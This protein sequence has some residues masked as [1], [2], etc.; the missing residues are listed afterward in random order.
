MH[1][2][3]NKNDTSIKWVENPKYAE[4]E[5][6]IDHRQDVVS[7]LAERMGVDVSG[8]DDLGKL[9]DA[10]FSTR[11]LVTAEQMAEKDQLRLNNAE[12]VQMIRRGS[13]LIN[14]STDPAIGDDP[15]AT[16]A[17]M[18][19]IR[20]ESPLATAEDG[21]AV[22]PVA[23][24]V[25][26]VDE[27][28]KGRSEGDGDRA[29]VYRDKLME[30][31]GALLADG[32]MDP[33]HPPY[34]LNAKGEKESFAAGFPPSL[35]LGRKTQAELNAEA[36]KQKEAKVRQ[37][38]KDAAQLATRS[39]D[40]VEEAEQRI[41]ER[42]QK[43]VALDQ[44]RRDEVKNTDSD[45]L[46]DQGKERDPKQKARPTPAQ[47]SLDLSDPDTK[48]PP[49]WPSLPTKKHDAPTARYWDEPHAPATD[50]SVPSNPEAG[51]RSMPGRAQ[52]QGELGGVSTANDVRDAKNGAPSP[53]SIR[54][55]GP[56]ITRPGQRVDEKR[57]G[58]YP[59][60]PETASTRS[61]A[62]RT[63]LD[64]EPEQTEGVPIDR[65]DIR[66][67]T[68][69][70]NAALDKIQTLTAANAMGRAKDIA[71][72][73]L[74]M[75]H[76]F[77]GKFEG[78][79]VK[80][81]IVA[82]PRGAFKNIQ[83]MVDG[84]TRPT[85][86]NESKVA[87][88]PG[89]EQ[90]VGGKFYAAPLA[91]I[92]TPKNAEGIVALAKDKQRAQA[93]VDGWRSSVASALL[94]ATD[95]E[96]AK[97][98]KIALAKLLTG[99]NKLTTW[100]MEKELGAL[101]KTPAVVAKAEPAPASSDF[102][103]MRVPDLM[104]VDAAKLTGRELKAWTDAVGEA[105][106][107]NALWDHYNES[108]YLS[109][110]QRL[111]KA[112]PTEG[113]KLS[114]AGT[115]ERLAA[116]EV[117]NGPVPQQESIRKALAYVRKVLGPNIK[118]EFLKDF[119]ADG[120]WV[121]AEQ[122]IKLA[123]NRGSGLETTAHHEA[124][125]G[126]FSRLLKHNPDAAKRLAG[127]MS[128]KNDDAVKQLNKQIVDARSLLERIEQS[129]K[130]RAETGPD[131]EAAVGAKH[132]KMNELAAEIVAATRKIKRLEEQDSDSIYNRLKGLLR[133]S[134][135][136]LAAM[137]RDPE[138]RVAYAYQFWVAG[139]LEVDK[140][141]TTIFAKFRKMLRKVLGMVRESETALDI[142]TAFH[143]G[144][145]AD[146]DAGAKA[147]KKIM[148]REK[149]NEDVKMKFDKVISTLH[150]ELSPAHEVLS[151]EDLSAIVRGIGDRMFTNPG[152]A[153]AMKNPGYINLRTTWANKFTNWQD[154]AVG[155]R[156]KLTDKDRV[157]VITALQNG[158]PKTLYTD[159]QRKAYDNV[160]DLLKRFHRYATDSGTKLEF[161]SNYFPRIW[162]TQ[163]L[164]SAE[165][166]EAFAKML[167]GEKYA[168]TIDK[169]LK[170][171]NEKAK[172]GEEKT[173]DD[174][175]AAVMRS[176]VD[177]GGVDDESM[178]AES[179][180]DMIF[181]PFFA[182][183]KERSFKW[184]EAEDVQPFLEKDLVGALSRYFQQGVRSVEFTRQFGESGQNLRKNLIMRGEK[185]F[186]PRSGQMVVRTTYGPAEQEMYDGLKAKGTTGKDAEAI[187]NRR[188]KNARNAVAAMEGSLGG[189]ISDGA[190][191]LSSN[192][193]AYQNLRLL[194][195][196]LFAAFGDVAGIGARADEKGLAKAY[197]A[198]MNGLKD[199]F[200]NWKR[201]ASD[202]PGPRKVTML[203]HMAEAMGVVS[204]H[205]Y[206]EQVGKAHTSEFM[207]DAARNIGRKLFMVNGL[208]A[209]D[210]SMRVTAT[211]FAVQFI[212]RHKSLPDKANSARWLAELG[213]QPG[214]ITLDKDGK[215]VWDKMELA[216]SRMTPNMSEKARGEIVT[217]AEHDVERVH[218]AV[219]RWVEGAVLSPNA[220]L[221]P[222]RA[223]DPHWSV[224]YHLKQ[225]T[226]AMHHVILKRAY[227]E[228]RQ[229]NM[230]PIGALAGVIPLMIVSDAFKGL[231]TNGGTLP[232]YMKAWNVGD[233][234]G[235]GVTRGGLTG[236][237]QFGLD[238][239]RDPFSVAGPTVEQFMNM[240]LH[241]SDL[242]KNIV[243]AIPGANLLGQEL[244]RAM[245]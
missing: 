189:D 115:V 222:S 16:Q 165:G 96:I 120:E 145:L 197:E 109:A 125:H 116:N 241:P 124:L 217:Q 211:K 159:D 103:K 53:T 228:A 100:S 127:V 216:Q 107:K 104:A 119:D 129:M 167:N 93:I 19:L 237:G 2:L 198:F 73:V 171:I 65:T 173:K 139:H 36:K 4:L 22:V 150:Y 215:L 210:R 97:H 138:E 200:A 102:A 18:N 46:L 180:G 142:M 137:E 178:D 85:E 190:R 175:I 123:L 105:A 48:L 75:F 89:K 35:K 64:A 151:K 101:V 205:M 225:F 117:Q 232:D 181:K 156:T 77:D 5:S 6:L 1:M 62:V 221:R 52:V 132:A 88:L 155:T 81:D 201:N 25:A 106:N 192:L 148:D 177:R 41:K 196:S 158:D 49:T 227:N 82:D 11:F 169:M 78:Q 170:T 218:S 121:D 10:Y 134:P 59:V 233:W 40:E 56:G 235:H 112:A 157:D 226:Y 17:S 147:I 108:K 66:N 176:L 113:R 23:D 144:Q 84:L 28:Q 50:A 34:M 239:M 203:E 245:D 98:N 204:S 188:M 140:P 191:K 183:N 184:I 214:D 83:Q 9:A 187:V 146:E 27:N 220:A 74:W 186:D 212:E 99:D 70:F 76:S 95:D 15:K 43:K 60:A 174:F 209:W 243:G 161:I 238:A 90:V 32:F 42:Q 185:E 118:V 133:D 7:K 234:I 152:D 31:I 69:T 193:I 38:K 72:R 21:I 8:A 149:W 182:S 68:S 58:R 12:V 61:D 130:N 57:S 172:Q 154:L 87:G 229:G 128:N 63:Q 30:G 33:K 219:V 194:P 230:N 47:G 54:E 199:V 179:M 45:E 242:G 55:G 135:D 207:T 86:L 126:F 122:L 202:M 111:K 213:L 80:S 26:W 39:P 71:N 14:K 131:A 206:L 244:S 231:L 114:E 24:L 110:L 91:N 236:L 208:T 162:N 136:A 163:H 224:F 29:H 143:Q 37:N 223:S 13:S 168:K 94:T 79:H 153:G 195:M 51:D 3:L 240:V 20:F 160:Q 67:F 141:A 44:Q 164:L 166:K 92:L